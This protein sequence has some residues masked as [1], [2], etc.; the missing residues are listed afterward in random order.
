MSVW[1]PIANV[2]HPNVVHVGDTASYGIDPVRPADRQPTVVTMEQPPPGAGCRAA[3]CPSASVENAVEP[4]ALLGARR[5]PGRETETLPG[6]GTAELE[7]D[8]EN[9]PI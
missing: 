7:H 4:A 5:R 8:E 3:T 1:A 2:A 6:G 9:Q